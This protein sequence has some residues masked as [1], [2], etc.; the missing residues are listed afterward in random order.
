[1]VLHPVSTDSPSRFPV[2]GLHC[3]PMIVVDDG[4]DWLLITQPDHARFAGE[5]LRLWRGDGL[6]EHPRREEIVFAGR[7]HD[8]GWRE[9]DAAPSWDA[10]RGRPHEFTTL[11]EG[12]RREIWERG[13]ARFADSRPAGALFVTLHALALLSGR[14][15]D[16]G[17]DE[18]LDRLE[19]R[20]DEL[21]EATG[22]TAE[23]AAG[24]YRFVDLADLASLTACSRWTEPFEREWPD[25]R[26][27]GRFERARGPEPGTLLLDPFPLA[28]A[29]TFR[30]PARR[31]PRRA[32]AGD[33]DL[34]GELAAAR[35]GEVA[36]RVAPAA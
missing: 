33:A 32:Y 23:E 2:S 5:L 35:W 20:R 11:P 1:M 21:R 9:A 28:G 36:V 19:E 3:L 16:P 6:A 18:T 17:W 7:E 29:T 14:R 8:N 13:T 34:G 10:A 4:P 15:G 30:V 24:D 26:R 27:H 12:D 22:L 31:I 25:G